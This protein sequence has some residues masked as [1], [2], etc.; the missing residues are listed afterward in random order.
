VATFKFRAQAALDLRRREYDAAQRQLAE[1][2]RD[3][4]LAQSR[5]Q[6]AA[7]VVID[8]T[9]RAAEAQTQAAAVHELEWYRFWIARLVHEREAHIALVR[10]REQRV[11]EATRA[12]QRAHQ[13]REALERFYDKAR[14]AYDAAEAANEMKLIDELATRRYAAAQAV[15]GE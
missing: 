15:R 11:A 4:H 12:C 1:T 6:Q 7:Q 13:K 10:T 5:Q 9:Q 14:Q 8:A 2:Q 3:L